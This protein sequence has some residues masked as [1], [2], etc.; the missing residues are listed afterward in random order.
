MA[1]EKRGVCVCGNMKTTKRCG[2]CRAV[3]YCSELCQRDDW[4]A[5]RKICKV[6]D[7]VLDEAEI[8]AQLDAKEA[9]DTAAATEQ[10]MRWRRVQ[11]LSDECYQL[12]KDIDEPKDG[13]DVAALR[14]KL[15]ERKREHADAKDA[16]V[17]ANAVQTPAAS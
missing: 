16:W 14:Q 8:K 15:A 3:W 13:V 10:S 11:D 1:S 2:R 9:A 6:A 7:S 17:K 4:K 5:H 12:Q